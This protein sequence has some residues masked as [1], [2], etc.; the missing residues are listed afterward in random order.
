MCT[1]IPAVCLHC[2]TLEP[3]KDLGHND[4]SDNKQDKDDDK[5]DDKNVTM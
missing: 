2:K 3:Y 5:D 4:S 1:H